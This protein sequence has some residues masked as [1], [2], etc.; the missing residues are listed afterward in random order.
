MYGK[1]IELLVKLSFLERYKIGSFM[2][3]ISV[4]YSA[5]FNISLSLADLKQMASCYFSIK[6]LAYSESTLN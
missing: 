3:S 4:I 6:T 5:F 1:N 2:V